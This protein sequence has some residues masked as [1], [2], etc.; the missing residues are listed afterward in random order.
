MPSRLTARLRRLEAQARSTD[1]AHGQGLASLL[2][3]IRVVYEDP[4]PTDRPGADAPLT[5]LARLLAEAQE[6]HARKPAAGHEE[7]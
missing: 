1:Q 2:A 3:S 4:P 7:T 6:D 5:G